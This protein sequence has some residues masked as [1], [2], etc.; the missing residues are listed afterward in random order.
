MGFKGFKLKHKLIVLQSVED[1]VDSCPVYAKT[2]E[3]TFFISGM[4]TELVR[5]EEMEKVLKKTLNM[6]SEKDLACIPPFDELE[7]T[8]ENIGDVLYQVTKQNLARIDMSLERLEIS[9]RAIETYIVSE[10]VTRDKFFVGDKKIK[11][12]SLL[13]E[14]FIS[15]SVLHTVSEFEKPQEQVIPMEPIPQPE[16]EEQPKE[17]P[18]PKPAIQSDPIPLM[19]QG[20]SKFIAIK[21]IFGVLCLMTIGS[22]IAYYLKSTGAY[23]SGSDIYGHLFKSDLLYHSI[24]NGDRYPLYT[25]LWYNGLQPFR[26]WAPLPYYLQ[27]VLQFFAGGNA[28]NSY[29]IFVSFSFVL[30]GIG[31]LIWGLTYRRMGFCTFLGC[32]W[33]FLPDNLRVFFVEGNFPRM[34]IAIF[35]PYLF[36]F[37]WRF[38]EGRR[39]RALVPIILIMGCITLSHVM[40]AAMTGI[41]TFIFLLI[42]SINQ[43]RFKES[44]YIIL[45]M[46]FAIASCGFWLYPALKGGLLGMEASVTEEVMQS[47]STPIT[48]SLNPFIRAYGIFDFFYF[49]LS[50]FAL[51]LIGVLLAN[52]K[53][54]PGFYTVIIILFGTT[55]AMVP[56]LDKLPLNQLFWM[57]RFTPIV[58]SIFLL[59]LLEWKNCRRYIVIIIVLVIVVD[60]L[61]S[62][63]LQRYHSQTPARLSYTLAKA[64]DLTDQRVSLID[65]SVFDSYPSYY[66]SAE[67]PKIKY[68]FGWAWQGASTSQNIVKINTAAEKGYYYY[69]FDRS[70]ELGDDTV[71][72]RKELVSKAKRSLTDLKEAGAA[73]GYWLADE[74]NYTYIFHKNTPKTFGVKSNYLGLAIGSSA[75]MISLSYPVFVEGVS[76]SITDYS[77]EELKRYRAIYLSDFTY[78]DRKAAE[79][80]LVRTANA[81]TK[82]IVD[83]NRIPVD[84]I[85]SRMTFF[86]VTAQSISFS[87]RYP[88]LMY[89][90]KIFEALPFK[91]GDSTWNTVYLEN[92]KNILG[93][94]WFQ[95]KQLAFLGTSGNKNIIFMGYNFLFHAMETD[96]NAILSLMT[97]LLGFEPNQVPERRIVPIEVQYGKDRILI[98]APAGGKVNT[99]I[100]Y[101]DIFRSDHK[102]SNTNNMLTV[103][104]QKTVIR[105]E[106]PYLVHG[107]VISLTG[108]LGIVIMLYILNKGRRVSI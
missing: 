23:P 78:S 7:P 45:A 66:F 38:A 75:N 3:I 85:T 74:T 14:N 32:L 97:D 18:P 82:I 62:M 90:G 57:T 29:L 33:F 51:S 59:S 65:L 71:L 88:E 39:K 56:F 91:K 81:G 27:A 28:L 93:Y 67:E 84:P 36:Y 99:T 55:T 107:L 77:F 70:I 101:Q 69:M 48:V 9:A 53:S 15:Q 83:M 86:D 5:F 43:R 58:Y 1:H 79:D 25:S 50:I 31:W 80:L 41:T 26:Y 89:Q 21:F 76:Q 19:E 8:L 94:S 104:G 64:K 22:L 49:G 95:N 96:D 11:I 46:I 6:Y 37:V 100:A 72:V 10:T 42:Y 73:S 52:K 40:V 87:T 30:G 47:L 102:I 24:K 44:I 17:V 60:C 35:L 106:Y 13:V 61:P 4:R 54:R 16:P 103:T 108:L 12:S 98:E 34:V 63:D 2:Y 105:M 92:A 68:S 20:E